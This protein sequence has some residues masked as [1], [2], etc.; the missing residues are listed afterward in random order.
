MIICMRL[1]GVVKV[2]HDKMI[3]DAL[4]V[5]IKPRQNTTDKK[6]RFGVVYGVVKAN[7]P[8]EYRKHYMQQCDIT[9]LR[10]TTRRRVKAVKCKR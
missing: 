5:W 8:E 2:T 3:P 10:I 4:N 7:T 6:G 9:E 1:V